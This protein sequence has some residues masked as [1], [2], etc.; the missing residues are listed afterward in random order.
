M[1]LNP[2]PRHGGGMGPRQPRGIKGP[3]TNPRVRQDRL[4]RGRYHHCLIPAPKFFRESMRPRVSKLAPQ[5]DAGDQSEAPRG[6]KSLPHRAQEAPKS[7]ENR[8]EQDEEEEEQGS[9]SRKRRRGAR[10]GGEGGGQE[11][12]ERQ[13][14]EEVEEAEDDDEEGAGADG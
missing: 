8:E 7:G 4:P 10:E 13:N 9:S 2:Q 5:T 12:A 1:A 6:P 11:T 3:K 14:G